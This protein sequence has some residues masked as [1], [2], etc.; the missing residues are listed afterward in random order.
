MAPQGL[1]ATAASGGAINLA[2]VD[3][4]NQ[5]KHTAIERS[6]DGTN[7]TEIVRVDQN[8]TTYQDAGLAGGVRYYYRVRARSSSNWSPYSNVASAVAVTASAGAPPS[9]PSGVSAAAV[10][11]SQVNVA[12]GA[13]TDAGGPGLKGYN[14]YRNGV[15]LR[16]IPAPTTSAADTGLSASTAYAY[17]VSAVD[18]TGRESTRASAP[19]VTTPACAD[20][21]APSVPTGVVAAPASCNQMNL[22]WNAATDSGG[23]GL[24]GYNVYRGGVYLKQV[25]TLS[26]SDA[27]L[28]GGTVYSYAVSAIDNAG[29]ESGRSVAASA[30][31]P[32]CGGAGINPTLTGY[33]P[34]V[35]AA[36]DVVLVG[37]SAYVASAEFGLARVDI[38]TPGAARAIAGTLPPFYGERAA[39]SGST[40]VVTTSSVGLK[41]I[42]LAA[43]G[44]PAV[45]GALAGTMKGVALA[46]RYAYVLQVIAGNPAHTDLIVVD[47]GLPSAPAVV[48]RVTVAGASE[49]VLAGS[50][51]YL[52]GG[53]AGLQVV[54]VTSPTAPRIVGTL[55]TPGTASGVAV[56]GTTAY[57]ADGSAVEV[58]D[59]ST[60]SRPVQR[61]SVAAP[62]TAIAVAGTRAYA[63]DGLQLRILDVSNAAAPALL[64]TST[65]YGA[66]RVA[67]AGTTVYLA[68]A[69]TNPALNQGGLYVIDASSPTAP[70]YLT[71]VYGGFDSWDMAMAGTVAVTTGNALGLRVVDLSAPSAPRAVGALAGTF[72]GVSMSGSYA[73]AMQIVAG[74]PAHTDLVVLDLR[75]P[76]APAIAGRVTVA[77]G[78]DLTVS[79]TRAYVAAGTAGLQIVDVTTP[80]APRVLGTVNTPGNAHAVAVGSAGYAYVADETAVRAV[81]VSNPATP[82]LR[83]SVAI[84]ATAI[85]LAGTR[86]Y[87]VDGL[88]LKILDVSSPAAPSLLSATA[89]YGAQAVDATG[90]TVMLA[91]PAVSHLDTS[92][93][94]FVLDAS[95]PTAPRLVRQV[96]VPGTTRS[97]RAGSNA[98][99]A[100]D[101]AALVD[102]ISF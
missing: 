45:A 5:E 69:N 19:G 76:S 35:G 65:G 47:V 50:L 102:V 98:C 53:G 49:L 84:T 74:N 14:L 88:Q 67:A 81:D 43:P 32:S 36:R 94:V 58:V 26:T 55:D 82:V 78:S 9:V 90:T 38:G 41:V 42:N 83:G 24:R 87:A 1:T 63:V 100:G 12:W 56:A 68:S 73:Y 54:D 23:A 28:A 80:T 44:G 95:S 39:V 30:N 8:V 101:S 60:P 22:S 40:A 96:I 99:Y 97:V 71:N 85:A 10:G 37:T 29:N 91:T 4:N 3:T 79:G 17:A 6:L 61:G 70:R 72:E 62:A 18:T 11:C 59:V 31:T 20:R 48:G 57:V 25:T 15:Y 21:T 86:V 46:G 34:G 89:G 66:Q 7:F 77:G 33:V 51:V 2:W 52:A 92:G 75:T 16:Q 64:S 93:G 27:G 13:S